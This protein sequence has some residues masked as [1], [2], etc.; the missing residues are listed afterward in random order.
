MS[1][2]GKPQFFNNDIFY[3]SDERWP[4]KHGAAT[5]FTAPEEPGRVASSEKGLESDRLI[6][7]SDQI[8][9]IC[10]SSLKKSLLL[11]VQDE[12]GRSRQHWL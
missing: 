6:G 9:Y 1:S 4:I 11:C 8:E 12:H 7:R 5:S 10:Q 2:G 3:I